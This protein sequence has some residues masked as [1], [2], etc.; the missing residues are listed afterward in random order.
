[1][2][3]L[4][5]FVKEV[6]D[7]LAGLPVK[8]YRVDELAGCLGIHDFQI[9]ELANDQVLQLTHKGHGAKVDSESIVS[10]QENPGALF[11]ALTLTTLELQNLL[12][13][14]ADAIGDMISRNTI[15]PFKKKKRKGYLRSLFK[16]EHLLS[17]EKEIEDHAEK[18][19]MRSESR[20][21]EIQK[22]YH[23]KEQQLLSKSISTADR[24]VQEIQE[25][26]MHADHVK[27]V[28]KNDFVL[29]EWQVN[30][31]H[32]LE[33]RNHVFVQAP[34]GAGK[35]AIVEEYLHRNIE[36]G[37]TL[38]YAVPIKALA[39]DKFFDFCEQYGRDKVGI[40]TGDITLNADA[41]IVVG[42][43]EIVRNI[44]FDR[45][46]AYHT[47]AFDEAQ[48]L[49]D[50]ERG[51]AWEES[52]IMCSNETLMIFLSGSV[53]NGETIVGWLEKIKKRPVKLFTEKVRPIPLKY[54]FPFGDGFIGEEDWQAL[55]D[56]SRKTGK[57][58]YEP[59]SEF[60]L[61]AEKAQ[62]LPL[63]LF[64]PRRR[65]CEEAFAGFNDI[66]QEESEELEKMLNDHPEIGFL[67]LKVRKMIVKKGC[68]YHHSGLLP[69]EKRII[70][71][72][73]KQGKLRVVSATMGLASGVNFS[74]RSCLISEYQ[75]PGN[76]GNMQTLKPSEILQMWGRAGR[77]RLDTEGYVIPC[78]D[79][80]NIEQFKQIDAYPEPIVRAQF[81]SPVNLL[82]IL[83]RF[84]TDMLEELCHKSL[85]SY[86]DNASYKLF[87]DSTMVKGAG[88]ICDVPTYNLPPYRQGVYK[89]YKKSR[90][91][92]DFRCGS[93]ENLQA[94]NRYYEREIKSNPL[95]RMVKHLRK[96]G[97]IDEQFSLTYKGRIAERFHSEIGLLV[98]HHLQQGKVTPANLIHYAATVS[99]SGHIDFL[100]TRKRL[101]LEGARQV[102]PPSLFPVMW[103]RHRGRPAFIYWNPGA[104]TIANRW[105]KA[106]DW[107]SFSEDPKTK[108]ILG[109]VFR[110]LLRTGELLRS[111]S[112]LQDLD[113][114]IAEAAAVGVRLLMRPPLVPEELFSDD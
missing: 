109:D 90:L 112:F 30:A 49:G 71:T 68:A 102:F 35:T 97:Y 19:W 78:S 105:V 16:L 39:N 83:N 73:A 38:F 93:C 108:H 103:E 65:D 72:M 64:M 50:E 94:C 44:L 7:K 80:N 3:I 17:R 8:T 46:D 76:S 62:M 52:I 41:P 20:S 86:V 113:P 66:P 75:R 88:A 25:L 82:S 92:Q 10:L 5:D 42:T 34:T 40:N 61:A 26:T 1:M 59:L 31:M 51:G 87:S 12:D 114:K 56:L 96:G 21:L 24:P 104:G 69:P 110:V 2:T 84:S 15:I 81:V 89:R 74:V 32:A 101:F 36:N 60:I 33:E 29:D 100:G 85:S 98:A 111:M 77:R 53:A 63:L 13:V 14:P 4:A 54:A 22:K 28:Q 47:I 18:Y 57:S 107:D 95:Q 6:S 37:V 9:R 45:P 79:I 67:N 106:K 11:E 55:Y 99:A 91:K 23:L 27:E 48:Y 70:E 58:F 43:T